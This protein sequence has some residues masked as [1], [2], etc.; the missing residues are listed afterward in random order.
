[1]QSGSQGT[2]NNVS[3]EERSLKRLQSQRECALTHFLLDCLKSY[4]LSTLVTHKRHYLRKITSFV[5]CTGT[6]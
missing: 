1:V 5:I 2:G 3:A 6:E 4:D